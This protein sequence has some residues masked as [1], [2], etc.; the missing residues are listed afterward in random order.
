[1]KTQKTIWLLLAMSFLGITIIINGCKNDSD[2]EP[3]LEKKVWA[4]GNADNTN[5][6]L[7]YFSAD[8]G[9]TWLRQGID[10]EALVGINLNDVWAVDE[11]IIWA[12]ARENI[13]VRTIDGGNSWVRIP[14]PSQDP[15][16]EL[17]SISLVDS[18]NIWISGGPGVVYNS[19]DG[20]DSWDSIQSNV[21][22]NN[23]LQ[24]IHAVNKEIIYVAGNTGIND[25]KGFIA[26][27]MDAG[28]T[29]DSIVPA[30]NYNDNNWI[31]IKSSDTNHIVIYGAI[32]RYMYS[33][34]AGQSWKN[35]SVPDTGGGGTGGADINCL[36]M[37]DGESWW[38]AFDLEGI[39][40]TENAGNS[41]EKQTSSGPGNMW[42]F[43]IDYYDKDHCV[44]VGWS[45]SSELGKIIATLNGGKIWELQLETEAWMN[46][47]SFIK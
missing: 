9:Y 28:Q 20:G 40:I 22:G 32:S 43:G 47:V 11:K 30:D 24:G 8:G 15:N 7:I 16:I 18:N 4:V 23:F 42:L 27:T 21:L 12:V 19:T 26:R 45:E 46:K 41:W 29:W 2:P 33:S 34:N 17:S 14:P 39:F 44:I 5:H 3:I 31:G 35:D 6:A 10:S 25:T 1:M 36:T 37:L 38:G 13:I